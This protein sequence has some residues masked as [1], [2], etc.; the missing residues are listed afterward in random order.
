MASSITRPSIANAA[1]TSPTLPARRKPAAFET[2]R[3]AF[4]GPYRGWDQPAAVEAGQ[5]SSSIAHGWSPIGA[6]QVDLE[7]EPG[8]TRQIVFLL[9][10][11]ENPE[12]QKF[13]P[14][15][16]QTINKTLVKPTIAKY[17]NAGEAD[18][19]FARLAQLL[20]WPLEHLP[21]RHARH[22]H[23]SHGEHLECLPVHGHLQSVA[24]GFVLRVGHRPR[25][26]LPRLQPGPAGLCAHGAG[27]RPRAHPRSGRHAT[28]H[29]RRLSPVP[30]ADQA[31]K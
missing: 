6:H 28:A 22:P 1:T 7:L 13:D 27:T 4:L 30:A 21:G 25:P 11:H 18:Q 20:G 9:G 2:R 24:L 23:Q 8:E 10:Y 26:G 31:R 3:D 17:L 19:A 12:D 5:L 16:S 14:P 29:G 15:G